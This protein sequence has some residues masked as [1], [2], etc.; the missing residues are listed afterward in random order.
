[1][2]RTFRKINKELNCG[3][4]IEVNITTGEYRSF[5]YNIIEDRELFVFGEYKSNVFQMGWKNANEFIRNK[6]KHYEELKKGFEYYNLPRYDYR[7][8]TFQERCELL[9]KISF[10]T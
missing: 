9:N 6:M 3:E 5:Y 10:Y 7:K 1:L 2:I 4:V 8:Y